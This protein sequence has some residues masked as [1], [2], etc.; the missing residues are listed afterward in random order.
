MI[1]NSLNIICFEVLTVLCWMYLYIHVMRICK[2]NILLHLCFMRIKL[3]YFRW[4]DLFVLR[5]HHTVVRHSMVSD[6]S[7]LIRY[8]CVNATLYASGKLSS[9]NAICALININ[10]TTV[11]RYI[12]LYLRIH[13]R[14]LC[15]SDIIRTRVVSPEGLNSNEVWQALASGSNNS[16]R[17]YYAW[18]S[19]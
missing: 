15:W 6:N 5:H 18:S 1:E 2:P 3:C 17:D 19:A 10:A 11:N 8:Y 16:L 14:R 13:D 9:C 4:P 7:K 12:I